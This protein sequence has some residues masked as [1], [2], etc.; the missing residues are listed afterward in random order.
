[1]KYNILKTILILI[2]SII[3]F[4]SF[5]ANYYISKTG[6]D[7]NPGT[8]SQPWATIS[9]A[10]NTLQAGDTVYIREGNYNEIIEPINNGNPGNYITYKNYYNE[11]V[12]IDRHQ[13][14][15]GS[16][17]LK[18]VKLINKNYIKI[19]GFIIKNSD[20]GIYAE[21]MDNC[22]I[23]NCVIKY[24][25]ISV[26]IGGGSQYNKFFNNTIQNQSIDTIDQEDDCIF[27]GYI[28]D[29]GI[30]N[31]Y[32]LFD[33]NTIFYGGHSCIEHRR[34]SPYI[35]FRNNVIYGG[36]D[37]LYNNTD[38]G[39]LHTLFEGNIFYNSNIGPDRE[40]GM[41]SRAGGG[42]MIIR[43][44]VFYH[45]SGTSGQCIL[46]NTPYGDPGDWGFTP[47]ENVK[48]YN[49]TIANNYKHGIRVLIEKTPEYMPSDIVVKNNIIQKCDDYEIIEHAKGPYYAPYDVI[50]SY[51][52]VRGTA[53]GQKVVSLGLG[54]GAQTYTLAEVESAYPTYFKD[55]IEGNP[56]FV[57]EGNHDFNLQSGSPCIDAGGHL[58]SV[59]PNDTGS[60]TSLIVVDAGYFQD[61]WGIDGVNADWIAVGNI[62]NTVQ[63]QS[64]NYNTNIITLVNSISRNDGDKVWLYRDSS[65]KRVLYGSAPDIGA[66]EF[67]ISDDNTPPAPPKGLKI[68][69]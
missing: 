32:N 50:F 63:I 48:I 56:L 67:T 24:H 53:D 18:S 12:I 57:D 34:N 45:T 3:H 52:L 30:E 15:H 40:G 7:T 16:R 17:T 29:G 43:N 59:H 27:L 20:R 58:T 21:N 39:S 55:N 64:I 5:A 37:K 4:T 47:V 28:S 44:N 62:N 51:N 31:S 23:Q 26:V 11:T 2:F 36:G 1:M 9:K 10:N 41:L 19:D 49:N 35:I 8:L 22:I 46:L 66:Y 61:G 68:I 6:S 13:Y 54:G 42:H 14:T 65:G 38:G 69:Q 25:D 60:G 33:S